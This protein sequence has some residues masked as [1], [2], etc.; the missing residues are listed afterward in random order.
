MDVH[1]ACTITT[2]RR[3]RRLLYIFR[4]NYGISYY[5]C[6]YNLLFTNGMHIA[7]IMPLP[8]NIQI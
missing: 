6:L 5:I 4:G 3:I 2:R 7:Y 8:Y 1:L